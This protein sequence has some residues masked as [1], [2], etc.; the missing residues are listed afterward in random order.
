M[1]IIFAIV[2]F[3]GILTFFLLKDKIL[4]NNVPSEFK[5]VYEYYLSC[6]NAETTQ[7]TFL[8]EQSGGYI[9]DISFSPGSVYMPFSNKLSFMGFGIPYWFYIS[10]NGL[11]KEQVPSKEK[12]QNQLNNFLVRDLGSCDFSSFQEQGFDVILGDVEDVQTK[13]LGKYVEVRVKQDLIISRDNSTWIGKSHSKEVKSSLGTL[14][15]VARKIYEYQKQNLFLEEYG[16][17]ILRLYAPVDGTEI[18]CSSKIWDVNKVRN[19]LVNALEANVPQTKIKGDYYVLSKEENKYFVKDIGENVNTNVNFLYSRSWPMRMQVWPSEEGVMRADPVGLQQGLGM[20]GF[21]YVPYHF[22]YDLGYPVLV[23]VSNEE[24]IFQ[25]PLV[26][27]ID[28]TKPRSSENISSMVN[29]VPELC[30][31]K[32][33]TKTVSTFSSNLDSVEAHLSFKC[34]DTECAIGST[35]IQD[36]EASFTGGFPQCVNGFIIASASGYKTK[37]YLVQSLE[38]NNIQIILDKKYKLNLELTTG[39]RKKP[40]YAVITF[41]KD[42]DTTTV[43][44]PEQS[45]V[46]LTEGQY[47]IKVYT[48]GFS[49]ITLEGSTNQKC[50]SVPKA[51]FLG[52]F[53]FNEEKCFDLTIPDQVVD[54]VISGGGKQMYY[55]T[56]S[57][58]SG[59][60]KIVI[61][62]EDFGVAKKAEDLQVNYNLIEIFGLDVS[63]ER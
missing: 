33:S 62:A 18:S 6:I 14:Y 2:I 35:K 61:N 44:Y 50:V 22:V 25:F 45:I 1:F 55:I 21:C 26:V 9:D 59:A 57:E 56:Q 19:D 37:K 11:K 32:I 23:Q 7:G 38:E 43:A 20:L 36:G 46:E 51:G 41:T 54:Q 24:E 28:K 15:D 17:D 63:F 34:F 27:Y 47:E 12:M 49:E 40:D 16:V 53:G 58:L 10:G 52:I 8:L 31:H 30:Q 60:K 13:I 4:P 5:P 48:Y 29:S 42:N 39:G 3:V